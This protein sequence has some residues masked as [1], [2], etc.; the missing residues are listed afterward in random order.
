M[1]PD[2]H[3]GDDEVGEDKMEDKGP[4]RQQSSLDSALKPIP[5]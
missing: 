2:E 1:D 4:A 3:N 5:Q